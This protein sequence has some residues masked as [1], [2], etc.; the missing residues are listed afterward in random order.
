MSSVQATIDPP[1]KSGAASGSLLQP[2]RSF[3]DAG[4]TPRRQ[5]GDTRHVGLRFERGCG[6]VRH[7]PHKQDRAGPPLSDDERERPVYRHLEL[8]TDRP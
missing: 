2:T 6:S 8:V 3:L 1:R 4:K 5:Y 7:A